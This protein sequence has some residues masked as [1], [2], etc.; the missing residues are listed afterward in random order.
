VH[1]KTVSINDFVIF[2]SSSGRIELVADVSVIGISSTLTSA[3]CCVKHEAEAEA[4]NKRKI[5]TS[6]SPVA[7]LSLNGTEA[8]L[9]STEEQFAES[10]NDG[11]G[12][13]IFAK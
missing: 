13:K 12:Y 11:R 9:Q 1:R 3:S 8:R 2:V 6:V 10:R 4:K 7:N 5:R